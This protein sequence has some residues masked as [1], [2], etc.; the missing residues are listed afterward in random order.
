MLHAAAGAAPLAG[1]MSTG[2]C[3]WRLATG[4]YY[5]TAERSALLDGRA[6]IAPAPP[7]AFSSSS[8]SEKKGPNG[9]IRKS[10]PF[11]SS[12]PRRQAGR[13]PSSCIHCHF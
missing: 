4:D 10:P 11:N 5:W 12:S 9:Q 1:V 7:L 2:K 13:G 3:H 8:S 6:Y